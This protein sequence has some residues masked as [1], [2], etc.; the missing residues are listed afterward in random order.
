MDRL[1]IIQGELVLMVGV[2]P[3]SPITSAAIVEASRVGYVVAVI[4]CRRQD[5]VEIAATAKLT[6]MALLA[7]ADDVSRSPRYFA[8]E[9][10]LQQQSRRIYNPWWNRIR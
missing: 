8:I 10:H 3:S 5:M 1:P 2:S 9:C 4:K 7:A 6:G